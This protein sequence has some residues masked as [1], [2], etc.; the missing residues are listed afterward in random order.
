M[1]NPKPKKIQDEYIPFNYS[2]KDKKKLN[3]SFQIKNQHFLDVIMNR[4]SNKVF[5][6]LSL[7]NLS[8]LLY[9]SNKIHE[10]YEEDSGY[11][12]SKRTAPS[13]GGRHPIDLLISMPTTKSERNLAY[14][15]PIDHSLNELN[16]NGQKLVSF[17]SEINENI[18][19]N[20]ACVIWFSIQTNKT[21]TKYENC[22]SLYWKDCGALLYCI[23]IVS[24]YIGL[25]SCPLGN[26]ATNGYNNI[27]KTDQLISGGGILVGL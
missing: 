23:Q 27:F 14:Y 16:I 22:E 15:N 1:N 11:I 13:A 7:E 24:N 19:I 6:P 9:F 21:Q 4:R 5:H 2:I 10:L 8:E 18:L 3:R 26:L 17:F 20:N 25:K 12:A